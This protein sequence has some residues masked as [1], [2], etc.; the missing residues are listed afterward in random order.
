MTRRTVFRIATASAA[1]IAVAA[2]LAGVVR[3]RK[4]LPFPLIGE[5]V[6]GRH[7]YSFGSSDAPPPESSPRLREWQVIGQP[8]AVPPDVAAEIR[9][10]LSSPSTY[11]ASQ[12]DCFLPGMAISFGDG[13][14]RVDVVI[15]LLCNRAV[16]YRGDSQ[17]PRRISDE[18]NR[19]LTS[20]YQRL[21]GSPPPSF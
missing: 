19:R 9:Q 14:S 6:V 8:V 18:G 10:I 2:T 3:H 4:S 16:F 20:V 5:P 11:L 17:I 21:F 7:V 13:D 1:I 15:C 12:S